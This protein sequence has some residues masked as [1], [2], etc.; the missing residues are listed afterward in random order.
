MHPYEGTAKGAVVVSDADF[1]GTAQLQ[2]AHS[3]KLAQVNMPHELMMWSPQD[4]KHMDSTVVG[5][6]SHPPHPPPNSGASW[7]VP[8][9][10]SSQPL[11]THDN[12]ENHLLR[13]GGGG[14]GSGGGGGGGGGG[15]SASVGIATGA[16]HS[17]EQM[18]T[19]HVVKSSLLGFL[20]KHSMI[21]LRDGTCYVGI[22]R[23]FDQFGNIALENTLC[24]HYLG[25]KVFEQFVGVLIIRGD[26]IVFIAEMDAN[27]EDILIRIDRKEYDK[28]SAE[29]A[30]KRDRTML[31]YYG[32][33]RY[34]EVVFLREGSGTG[35]GSYPFKAE[36]DFAQFNE[37]FYLSCFGIFLVLAFVFA[38]FFYFCMFFFLTLGAESSKQKKKGK[39]NIELEQQKIFLNEITTLQ[40]KKNK[41]YDTTNIESFFVIFF[42]CVFK[43][44]F[45][46]IRKRTFFSY[47]FVTKPIYYVSHVQLEG[48]TFFALDLVSNWTWPFSPYYY[49][50]IK[51]K[52]KE[53]KGSE[54]NEAL[55]N[56][57]EF[58]K[59]Q[60]YNICY[61]I[62]GKKNKYSK[63][64]R[65][66]KDQCKESISTFPEMV[67]IQKK[68]KKKV[69]K[70]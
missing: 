60:K 21:I 35:G 66:K 26:N 63:L 31:K 4:A 37:I 6:H 29:L 50:T 48:H 40:Q 64:L 33:W 61:F 30:K 11:H 17:Q 25:K 45:V 14:G 10:S 68:K 18:Y 47:I 28:L 43:L 38:C 24:R 67:K 52:R 19:A 46:K 42:L 56:M 57:Q 1:G 27:K 34:R 2:A 9:L 49:W 55:M 32:K 44:S 41:K 12:D 70:R 62:S 13:G 69:N 8:E 7:W 22:V 16:E 51:K 65:R 53:I 59:T 15:G 54:E 20:D 39:E 58:K 3:H 5:L 23:T 36:E